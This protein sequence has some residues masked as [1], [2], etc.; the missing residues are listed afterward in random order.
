MKMRYSH[1]KFPLIKVKVCP[2]T[3][4]PIKMINSQENTH[5][6][7]TNFDLPQCLP[8]EVNPTNLWEIPIKAAILGQWLW[9]K[10]RVSGNII[11]VRWPSSASTSTG[12]SLICPRFPGHRIRNSW[13]QTTH[14]IGN[15]VCPPGK[16]L[17]SA[18]VIRG[19]QLQKVKIK[20]TSLS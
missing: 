13:S 17:S 8:Y 19:H 14:K 3:N 4:P 11:L 1:K 5:R 20:G 15:S 9:A 12:I 18:R 10:F 16:C 6:L 7:K 2:P